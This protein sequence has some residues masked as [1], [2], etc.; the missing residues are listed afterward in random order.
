MAFEVRG[1]D[2][3]AAVVDLAGRLD[4][5]GLAASCEVTVPVD[6]FVPPGPPGLVLALAGPAAAVDRVAAGLPAA[7]VV[8]HAP[9]PGAEQRCRALAGRRVRLVAGRGASARLSFVRCLNVLMAGTGEPAVATTDPRL[10]AV[11]GERAAWNGRPPQSWE[12]VMPW[13]EPT[14]EQRRLLAAG[15]TVRVQVP[16]AEARS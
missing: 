6:R 4:A 13:G 1:A 7:R 9:E 2:P 12:H 16:V 10:I 15:H 11:T 14:E 5:A 3:A 8:V